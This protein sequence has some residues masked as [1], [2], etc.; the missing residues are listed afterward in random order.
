MTDRTARGVTFTATGFKITPETGGRRSTTTTSSSALVEGLIASQFLLD[1]QYAVEAD[2]GRRQADRKLELQVP[3]DAGESA[4]VLIEGDDGLFSWALPDRSP[5]GPRRRSAALAMHF[6]LEFDQNRAQEPGG[7]RGILSDWALQRL[8]KPIRLYVLRFLAKRSIDA[9]KAHIEG[10]LSTGPVVIEGSDPTLWRAGDITAAKKRLPSDRP[11]HIL[12]LVHGTFSSTA[13]SFAELAGSKL[14]SAYDLVLG[15]DH[16]TLGDTPEANAEAILAT[17]HALDLSEDS[18]IDAIAFSRGGLVYRIL[19]EHLVRQSPLRAQ[20]GSA[21][22]VGCTNAGTLLAEPD[23]WKALLDTYTNIT[24]AA[25][26]IGLLA[27]GLSAASPIVV[28]AIRMLGGF[29]QMLAQVA[30]T[31]RYLPGLAAMEPGGETVSALNGA[32]NPAESQSY[33]VVS[34]DF[35]PSTEREKSVGGNLLLSTLDRVADRL[36]GV[37]NDLVVNTDSMRNFGKGKSAKTILELPPSSA[38]YHTVYF[39]SPAVVGHIEAWLAVEPELPNTDP[40][41]VSEPV[42]TLPSTR[43]DAGVLGNDGLGSLLEKYRTGGFLG[44]VKFDPTIIDVDGDGFASF[45]DA[46]FF[47]P[48]I[49]PDTTASPL[50]GF[51]NIFGRDEE[52]GGMPGI[53]PGGGGGPNWSTGPLDADG[54]GSLLPGGGPRRKGSITVPFGKT[55]NWFLQPSPTVVPGTGAGEMKAPGTDAGASVEETRAPETDAG[56][57]VDEPK[58]A[59]ANTGN[60]ADTVERFMAAEM[61]PFPRLGE[62]TSLYVLI[63]PRT[64]SITEHDAAAATGAM[65]LSSKQKLEV[66]VIAQRN[67]EVVDG[68][69]RVF[70]VEVAEEQ[71]HRF[72]IRGLA[73]GP[74]ELLVEARQGNATIATLRLDPVFVDPAPKRLNAMSALAALPVERA[75]HA[76]LRIYEFKTQGGGLRLQFNLTSDD[77]EIAELHM[78]ANESDLSMARYGTEVLEE[79]ERAWNL[80]DSANAGT[81]YKSFHDR[82]VDDAK[83]RSAELIPE[84][85]RRSLWEHRGSLKAIQVISNEPHIPWELMFLS[86]PDGSKSEDED[87]LANWGLTRWLHDA[88]LNRRRIPFNAGSCRYV[89]PDYGI[90]LNGAVEERAMLEEFVENI[91]PIEATSSNV[92]EFLKNDAEGCALLHFACHGS[93]RHSDTLRSDL[94]M[95]EQVNSANELIA[96]PLIWQAVKENADFGPSGG[97]LVFV[98]ACQ[99]GRQGSSIGGVAGFATA[100]LRPRSRRGAAAFIGALWSVD[101]QL[102]HVFA[103]TFYEGLKA[104]QPL[105]EAVRNAR[106]ACKTG[107][108]F[109]WL[110][111]SVYGNE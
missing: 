58:A 57:S 39:A 104:G 13:G 7:R 11:P 105:S 59:E 47:S 21:V 24:L 84:P 40:P 101:D 31:D 14:F 96:D 80:R 79:V 44:G 55:G 45:E 34:A 85:I 99:T 6:T 51:Q 26:R 88:P 32:A 19:I 76:V 61:A 10:G 18:R 20:F 91:T 90:P 52:E 27:S 35:E 86:D 78:L 37:A 72:E 23:N 65:P 97:P 70:D 49:I 63:S 28:E 103:R 5:T 89:I 53:F 102:A 22:F 30:I 9:V 54:R 8:I 110:A 82:I 75:P 74:A 93:A 12:L 43:R 87:F 109:T 33:F 83:N 77:P 108:D 48:K 95:R 38:V 15:Y 106:H 73:A 42:D 98:N 68:W 64:I 60:A 71:T 41:E 1:G 62:T 17:L 66:V 2:T 25:A 16:R 92:R 100:F 81:I 67:C 4:V 46:G 29:A 69:R 3:V 50:P 107:N 94:I 111:Y 56:A 36:H